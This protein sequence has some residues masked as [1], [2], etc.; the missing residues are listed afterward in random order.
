MS[1]HRKKKEHTDGK[2]PGF[3][4]ISFLLKQNKINE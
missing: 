4:L 1:N 2:W 3:T